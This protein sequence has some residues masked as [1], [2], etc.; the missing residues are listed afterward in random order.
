MKMPPL[1]P[2][3]VPIRDVIASGD[4]D[5]M[6]AMVRVSDFCAKRDGAEPSS[7]WADA[8]RDL[9]RAAG[10]GAQHPSNKGD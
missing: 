3:G 4:K 9:Q 1:M 8:H 5:L 2:Y 10:Q 7:D 6:Q